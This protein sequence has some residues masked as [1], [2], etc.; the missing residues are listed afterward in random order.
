LNVTTGILVSGIE[1]RVANWESYMVMS[2]QSMLPP[3]GYASLSITVVSAKEAE[4]LVIDI[5]ADAPDV[6][7]VML[8]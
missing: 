1:R 8:G 5:P 7:E 6:M 2:N 4:P 3:R